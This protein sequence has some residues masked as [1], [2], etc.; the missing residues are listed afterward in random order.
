MGASLS[1]REASP[2][3]PDATAPLRGDDD[4][5]LRGDVSASA[6]EASEAAAPLKRPRS[7]SKAAAPARAGTLP[8]LVLLWY[9]SSCLAVTTS[10]LCMERARVPFVLC[11]CQ[12]GAATLLTK[13]LLVVEDRRKPPGARKPHEFATVSRV[14]V[15]CTAGFALTNTAFTL[16]SAPFVETVKVLELVSTAVLAFLRLGERERWSTYLALVPIVAGVALAT[17]GGV[18]DAG[19]DRTLAL[20]VI[21]GCNVCFSLRGVFV[22]ELHRDCPLSRPATSGVALFHDV[23]CLGLPP[24]VLLAAMAERDVLAAVLAARPSILLARLAVNGFAHATYQL[25]SFLVLARAATTTHAVLNVL[26]RVATIAATAV[27]FRVPMSPLNA[28]GVLVAVAG[29]VAFTLSK[30][31][32]KDKG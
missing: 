7:G 22:K 11:A 3:G 25:V 28:A 1:R 10:K 9:G 30:G 31:G 2:D 16:A 14:A 19:P 29:F 17:G 24:L 5:A 12:F 27:V 4:E 21:I 26:R 8:L 13:A 6:P 20:F 15:S 23:S 32:R 18:A